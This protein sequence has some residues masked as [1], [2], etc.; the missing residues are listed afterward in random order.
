MGFES[1]STSIGRPSIPQ[2]ASDIMEAYGRR[3]LASQVSSSPTQ[4]LSSS[5]P[6]SRNGSFIPLIIG[7]DSS[8]TVR[9]RIGSLQVTATTLPCLAKYRPASVTAT[10][11]PRVIVHL[12]EGPFFVNASTHKVSIPDLFVSASMILR[13]RV[14]S[15]LPPYRRAADTLAEICAAN[16]DT[17][18]SRSLCRIGGPPIRPVPYF[19]SDESAG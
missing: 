19:C 15:Q 13:S 3:Y 11:L 6:L 14:M 7:D 8:R 16:F 17:S 5:N 4:S 1:S 9:I 18:S 12:P 10:I 2:L